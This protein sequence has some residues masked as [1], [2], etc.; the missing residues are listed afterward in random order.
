MESTGY[1]EDSFFSD[2]LKKFRKRRKLTQSQLAN[3]I[4]ASRE[5]VSLWER[6]EYKPETTRMVDA[7]VQALDLNDQEKRLLFEAY[8]GTASVL[9]LHNFPEHNPYFTG[10][11]TILKSLHA[12]LTTDKPVAL[13]QTQAISGLGGIGKTQVAIEYAYRF[14][15]HYHDILWVAAESR[16]ILMDSYLTLARLLRLREQEEREQQKVVEAVKRWFREHKDWLLILDNVEDLELVREFV[17]AP[18]QGAVVFTTRRAE[19]GQ[20]AKAIVLDV[21]PEEEGTLFLLRRT[22]HLALEAALE[23]A[24]PHHREAARAIVHIVGG[25]PLALDQAGAYVAETRCSLSHYLDLFKREQK[26][27][28]HRRGTVPGDH[29]QSVATTFSL[30]IEQIQRKNEAAIELLTLCTCLAPD[31]IPLELIA[32]GA[33]HLGATLEPVAADVLQLDQALEILQ[34]YSLVKRDGENRTLSMHRLVQAVLKDKLEEGEKLLWAKRAILAVNAAFPRAETGTWLQCERLLPHSL[35]VAQYIET[36]QII[37]EEAGHLLY[38]TA[39]YLTDRA[40][41]PEAEKLYQR[42][43]SI[44]E[45]LLGP[46]HPNVATSL[47]GLANLYYEQ[48]KYAEAESLYQ[49]TLLIREQQL[50]PDHLDVAMSLNGLANLYVYQGKY[51]EAKLFYQ[52]A[53]RIREQQLGLNHPTMIHLLNGLASLYYMQGEYAK[54]EPLFQRALFVNEQQWG[55]DNPLAAYPLNNLAALYCEQGKYAEAEL[56]YQRALSI[57]E[58]QLG[59]EHPLTAYPLEGLGILYFKQGKYAEA[60]LLYQRVLLINEQQLGP[61][62]LQVAYLLNNLAEL[63]Y[64]QRKYVEAERLYQRALA[65]MEQQLGLEHPLVAYPLNGLAQLSYKRRKYVEAERLYQRA[66]HIREQALG[67]R[68]AGTAETIHD[69]AQLQE[70]LGNSEEA[71]TLYARTLA[72]REQAL[73]A[74]HP[75]TKETR[76]RLIA[77]HHVMGQHEEASLLEAVQAERGTNEEEQKTHP[78]E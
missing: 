73:G 76:K 31:A 57:R 39:S 75:K 38:E 47:N 40:H 74:Q 55:P 33:I 5:A 77:L 54:A 16:E 48:G 51:S 28:L 15:E 36:E 29:P 61:S 41:Y 1:Q 37:N 53:L 32:Q 2:L 24:S 34:A 72:I 22:G 11:E 18:R 23:T 42:A 30:A 13:I 67:S 27:L 6:G 70:T 63:Y 12:H 9:P 58:Q 8:V 25:L 68:H 17:P 43:L 71:R 64:E 46:E 35:L 4:E 10:R 60:E 56:L 26:A 52:R 62:H 66:L 44:Q 50:G 65:T 19:T 78:E 20:I 3:R 49:R 45:Q 7:L 14:R 69:L 59:P 21:M